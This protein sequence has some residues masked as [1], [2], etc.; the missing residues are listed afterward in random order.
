M[1]ERPLFDYF[2][3]G[4]YAG[5]K[6]NT[7]RTGSSCWSLLLRLRSSLSLLAAS[8]LSA[9]SF[10]RRS[11][12]SSLSQQQQNE[13]TTKRML[14]DQTQIYPY[15]TNRLATSNSGVAE[16]INCSQSQSFDN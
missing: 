1:T 12:S 3:T 6:N 11:R 15:R 16:P 7:L 4:A 14:F 13:L 9:L 5:L 8:R 2:G 10:S